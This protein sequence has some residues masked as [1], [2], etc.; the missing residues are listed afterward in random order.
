[1]SAAERFRSGKCWAMWDMLKVD[2]GA[3]HHAITT[4]ENL[5][6]TIRAFVK[7]D[8]QYF[9][10]VDDKMKSLYLEAAH[11]IM[12]PLQTLE[13]SLAW[14]E[15]ER[16]V[17]NIQSEPS[18]SYRHIAD[19]L[20]SI[21][22]RLKDELALRSVYVLKAGKAQYFDGALNMF[23]K[24]FSEKFQSATYEVD[25]AGKCFA[26]ERSS[27]CVFHLMRVL[28]IGIY[29]ASRSLNI[30]DPVK[31]AARNWGAMLKKVSEELDRKNKSGWKGLDKEFFSEIYASLE[32][33]SN[34]WRNATMHIETKYTPDE[35]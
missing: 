18:I 21:N 29:A 3:F 1:M 13:A 20:Q 30:P 9:A 8:E 27:A 16:L 34:V 22:M 24:E 15:A 31:D 28:E 17:R 6:T 5:Q 25:E 7:G 4:I 19:S 12:P 2:A 14:M 32:A 33:V 35:A 26:L 23:G 11:S 10:L